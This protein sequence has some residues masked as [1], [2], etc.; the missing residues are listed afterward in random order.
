M[1]HVREADLRLVSALPTGG[2]VGWIGPLIAGLIAA[3][4]RLPNLSRPN[5]LIFDEVYYAVDALGLLRFGSERVNV[6]EITELLPHALDPNWRSLELFTGDPQFVV[7]PPAG[8]WVIALGEWIFGA[9]TFG[10][11]IAVALLG[12]AAVVLLARIT[13]RLTRSNLLGGIAGG[14]LALDG[15]HIVL[16]RT[17]LLDAIVGFWVLVTFGLLLWDR[18][19]IRNRLALRRASGETIESLTRF[20]IRPLRWAAAVALGLAIS[21]KWSGL[22]FLAAFGLLTVTWD[23]LTRR[24]LGIAHPWLAT[25]RLD[26]PLAALS[27]VGIAAATYLVTWSGW[28]F[29]EGGWARDWARSEGPSIVPNWLRSLWHYHGQQWTF[30]SSLDAEHSYASNPAGWLIQARPTSF[31][32]ESTC[33]DGPCAVEVLALGNPLVWWVGVLALLFALWQ[34]IARHDWRAGAVLTGVA[35]GWLPW[36]AFPDRPVFTFYSVVFIPFIVMAIA[37]LLQTVLGT[38]EDSLQRRRIGAAITGGY[39]LAVA[40]AAWW[41]MPIWTAQELTPDAWRLRMWF[42]S[43]I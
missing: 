22:W 26:A 40:L 9:T 33:A 20:G 35:A 34:L 8:K 41:F 24:E 32:Y 13:R 3:V 15:M 11:R 5:S 39:L 1:A 27:T 17:A 42:S 6:K 2:W 37:L 30:H 29:T 23:A 28:I 12:I 31:S 25:L 36:L 21:T 16:S 10:W 43:W 38:P 7:H 18:D 4:V 19:W 14:L